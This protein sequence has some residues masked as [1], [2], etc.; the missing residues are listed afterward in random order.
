LGKKEGKTEHFNLIKK[1]VL[2]KNV[3]VV[4]YRSHVIQEMQKHNNSFVAYSLG[5]CLFD[6]TVSITGRWMVKQIPEN[7]K[8]FIL[9][10]EI[11][12]GTLIDVEYV[13]FINDDIDGLK[14]YDIKD[15]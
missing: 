8:S 12:D 5:N 11:V 2:L 15:Y 14:F 1:L 13:G 4:R 9:E 7:K 3:M 10:V 6:D